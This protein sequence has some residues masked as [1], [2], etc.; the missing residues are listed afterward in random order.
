MTNQTTK[1][2]AWAG[3]IPVYCAHDEIV[4]IEKEVPK[5]EFM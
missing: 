4:K 1:P 3:D 2:K 5:E